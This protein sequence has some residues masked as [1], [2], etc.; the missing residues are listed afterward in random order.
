MEKI[1]L[2]ITAS[3]NYCN[4]WPELHIAVNN[5]SQTFTIK[6]DIVIDLSFKLPKNNTLTFGMI[7]K[8]FGKNGIWDTAIDENSGS[9]VNDKFIKIKDIQIN[10]VSVI[11]FL[12]KYFYQSDQ[13]PIQIHDQTLRFNG[14]YSMDFTT[15]IYNWI[16][17]QRKLFLQ[18]NTINKNQSYFSNY[19]NVYADYDNQLKI[20]SQLK[21]ILK[22]IQ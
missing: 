11:D 9:I 8:S 2:K 19:K 4:T 22:K 16:I 12:D 18:Q 7:N 6:E 20:I 14:Q 13:E 3:G 1:N 15:P 17:G 21:K 5:I 10:E